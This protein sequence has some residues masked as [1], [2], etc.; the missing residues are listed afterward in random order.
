MTIFASELF[1]RAADLLSV[2]EERQLKLATAESCTGGLFAA[3]L[4]E[5]PGSSAVLERGFVSYSNSSKTELLDVDA[6]LIMAHGAVS[7]QV[8]IAMAEGAVTRSQADIGVSIT[9]VAGPDGG[10]S[11]KP[12]GL[13]HLATYRR[14]GI[15]RHK[16]CRFGDRARSDIRL[17]TVSEALT[18]VLEAAGDEADTG[19]LDG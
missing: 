10:T 5:V 2:L 4:T 13:V 15:V 1:D 6:V 3:L 18:L 12:V 16:E 17:A 19:L 9:G 8:A 11:S 7:R 14:G